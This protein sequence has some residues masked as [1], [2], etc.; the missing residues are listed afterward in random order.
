MQSHMVVNINGMRFP[1]YG[2]YSFHVLVDG[3]Q[4]HRIGLSV[5]ES[6]DTL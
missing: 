4:I 6:P 2:D 1:D 5:V 3:H